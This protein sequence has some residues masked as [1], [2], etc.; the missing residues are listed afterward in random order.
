MKKLF[1]MAFSF[2]VLLW[3]GSAMA[4]LLDGGRMS[5]VLVVMIVEI[6]L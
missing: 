2:T 3:S 1:I 6:I 5:A 4:S